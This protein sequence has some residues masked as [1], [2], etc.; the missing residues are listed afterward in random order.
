[1]VVVI[2]TLFV[3]LLVQ[4][5]IA[6]NST[7]QPALPSQSLA[8]S[9]QSGVDAAGAQQNSVDISQL[10]R[11]VVSFLLFAIGILSVIMIIIGGIRYT[12]SGG[13]AGATKSA[14]D[15]ILYSIIGLVVAFVAWGIVNFVTGL[16]T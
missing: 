8:E 11:Q 1:M 3:V 10:I 12:I 6:Q 4:P 2:T 9:A 16:F 7:Q 14:R 15:T 13:D 5:A